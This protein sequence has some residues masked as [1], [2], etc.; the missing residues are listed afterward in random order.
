MTDPIAD[1]L[2]RMRNAIKAR[3]PKTVV[4]FSNLKM[5]VLEVFKKHRYVTD[6]RTVKTGSY[7]EIEIHFNAEQPFDSRR[8][9]RPGQRIYIKKD[10]I[11]PVQSG[12]GISIVSTPRGVMTGSEAR[13]AGIGGELL[14][15]I[16]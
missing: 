2:T 7:P 13:K 8:M 16:W 1:L 9:S 15:E 11:R 3:H 10:E 14:C 4:P 5:A 6:Y 12:Y